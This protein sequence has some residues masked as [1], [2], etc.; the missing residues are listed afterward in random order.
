[1]LFDLTQVDEIQRCYDTFGVV[2]I[3][4]ILTRLKI[5]AT[6]KEVE[7]IVR[8]DCGEKFSFDDPYT[9]AL[10]ESYMNNFGVIGKEPLFTH[11][12]IKNRLNVNVQRAYSIVYNMDPSELLAQYDRVS[13]MRQ[14]I[15]PN[16]VINSRIKKLDSLL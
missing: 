12:L 16:G 11:Q 4:G 15:G 3:T 14:S 2:G 13:W 7:N 10:T 6:L 5:D 8:G 9:Y 1:M